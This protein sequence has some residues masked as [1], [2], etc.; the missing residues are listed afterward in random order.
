[1]RMVP[2]D[3]VNMAETQPQLSTELMKIMEQRMLAIERRSTCLE[4]LM[5]QVIIVS[6]FPVL[7][8]NVC[9]YMGFTFKEIVIV[10]GTLLVTFCPGFNMVINCIIVMLIEDSQ[11]PH[12]LSIQGQIKSSGNSGVQWTS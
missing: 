4:N 7:H 1:M 10:P 11:K 2:M 12:Q 6:S 8:C 5:N 3:V 9:L